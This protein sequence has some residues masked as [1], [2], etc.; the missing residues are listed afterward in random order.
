M[1]IFEVKIWDDE[2]AL[3]SFYTVLKDGSQVTETDKFFDKYDGDY[4]FKVAAGELLS[5]I[6]YS[7]GD[8]HGA[9]D[10]LFNRKENEVT[11][12]PVKGEIEVGEFFYYYPDFPLRIYALKI[13]EK[14]VVLFNG[15]VKDGS[16]N[17]T[18][19]LHLQWVEACQFAKAIMQSINSK[20]I[21]IDKENRK[22][23]NSKGT[24]EIVLII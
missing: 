23:T 12:L 22:I 2:A 14:I 4:K 11:G 6:L 13:T 16:K 10:E 24:E 20:E 17:Q 3:C 9:I 7:V 5:F 21:I 1:N 15:G 18:S 19:S 8:D